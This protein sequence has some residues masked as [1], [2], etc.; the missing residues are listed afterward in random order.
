[1]YCLYSYQSKNGQIEVNN[2]YFINIKNAN[3]EQLVFFDLNDRDLLVEHDALQ[4][5][6]QTILP[7]VTL[8]VDAA[9]FLDA[10]M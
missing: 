6:I 3:K 4:E 10:Y 1:M 2:I 8:H 9:Q 7:T 5:E